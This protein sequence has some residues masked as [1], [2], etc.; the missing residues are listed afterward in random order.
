MQPRRRPVTAFLHLPPAERG[1]V[2][3]AC[4]LF[5]IAALG[6][7]SFGM[8]RT[9]AALRWLLGVIP[10]AKNERTGIAQRVPAPR[11]AALIERTAED[12]RPRPQCLVRSLVIEAV[13]HRSGEPAVLRLG[14]R[15]IKEEK[16]F[17]AHAWV[18]LDGV[19]LSATAPSFSAF[20]IRSAAPPS[21]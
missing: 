17:E 11:I 19:A 13:L 12:V 6:V 5:P 8:R 15:R 1:V 2:M 18:E 16:A 7:R 21:D 20:T 4:V 3:R 14:A 9:Q 10:S